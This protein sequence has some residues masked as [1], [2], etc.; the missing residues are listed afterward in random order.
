MHISAV[1]PILHAEHPRDYVNQRCKPVGWKCCADV[2]DGI[3]RVGGDKFAKCSHERKKR[4]R[5]AA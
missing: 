5:V 2:S 3:L 4:E 1:I